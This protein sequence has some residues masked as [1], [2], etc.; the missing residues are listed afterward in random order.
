M[1]NTERLP[2]YHKTYGLIKH[3]YGVIRSFPK[4]YKYSMGSEIMNLSWKC[5][6]LIIEANAYPNAQKSVKV[7]ELSAAYDK[8][9]MRLRM[10]Q[11][12]NLTSA[13]QFA[14][15]EE[16]YMLEIGKMIGGW[17]KWAGAE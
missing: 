9:K 8:L 10:S 6:D 15:L 12:I 5:L 4:E 11:E 13:G 16:N 3:L 17:K 1:R 2:L 14:H 7:A